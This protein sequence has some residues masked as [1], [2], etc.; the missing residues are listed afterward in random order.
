MAEGFDFVKEL[1]G[2]K[3][4]KREN[5]KNNDAFRSCR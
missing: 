1:L 2:K 3:G 5:M 4:K